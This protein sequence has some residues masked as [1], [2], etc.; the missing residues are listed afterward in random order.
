M[1][2]GSSRIYKCV[3]ARAAS[4]ACDGCEHRGTEDE[5]GIAWHL[6]LS[7]HN[8]WFNRFAF[9]ARRW[10]MVK[11]K[12]VENIALFPKTAE[13]PATPFHAELPSPQPLPSP[14]LWA[15]QVPACCTRAPWK[16]Q[17]ALNFISFPLPAARSCQGSCPRPGPS[18]GGGFLPGSAEEAAR[19][20]YFAGLICWKA[21]AKKKKINNKIIPS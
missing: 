11:G 12:R 9:S 3:T 15:E 16:S 10:D 2:V 21:K 17:I 14:W 19:C 7:G 18:R 8:S 1:R 20:S 4:A 13:S 5:D 6:C